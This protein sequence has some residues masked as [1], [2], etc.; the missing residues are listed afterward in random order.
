[1][2]TETPELQILK[3]IGNLSFPF[4]SFFLHFFADSCK[5]LQIKTQLAK[6]S[7]SK[8]KKQLKTQEQKN[9]LRKHKN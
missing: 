6:D 1:L 2:H 9:T 3:V 7:T 8:T 4:S 5:F